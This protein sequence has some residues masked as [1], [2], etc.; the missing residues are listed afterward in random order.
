MG[1]VRL[2]EVTTRGGLTASNCQIPED[3]HESQP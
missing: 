2:W 1:G 3:L